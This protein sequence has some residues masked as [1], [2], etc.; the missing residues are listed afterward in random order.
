MVV[1]AMLFA[2]MVM[3]AFAKNAKIGQSEP[4]FGNPESNTVAHCGPLSDFLSGTETNLHG[5]FPSNGDGGNCVQAR[6]NKASDRP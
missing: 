1:M 3:P 5:A 4:L 6:R 2:A